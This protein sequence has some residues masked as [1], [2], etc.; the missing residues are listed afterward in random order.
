MIS[1]RYGTIPV[2]RATGG[3]MDTIIDSTDQNPGTGFLFEEIN[4]TVFASRMMRAIS[5]YHDKQIWNTIKKNAM[6]QDFSWDISAQKYI[7][8]YQQLALETN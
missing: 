8:E 7:H 5:N 2:A 4:S 1:Q 6:S 3:L